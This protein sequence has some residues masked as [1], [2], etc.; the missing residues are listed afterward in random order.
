MRTIKIIVVTLFVVFCM[1]FFTSCSSDEIDI[2]YNLDEQILYITLPET[3]VE[4]DYL[5]INEQN[6]LVQTAK[7]KSNV[8]IEVRICDFN[9]ENSED[10][11]KQ[12]KN[13]LKSL[14]PLASAY[15]DAID[16]NISRDFFGSSLAGTFYVHFDVNN[17]SEED[18][19]IRY[20]RTKPF[21]INSEVSELKD[22]VYVIEK[23]LT[24]KTDNI[25]Y[26]MEYSFLE[27]SNMNITLNIENP[28]PMI[29]YTMTHRVSNTQSLKA[30]MEMLGLTVEFIDAGNIVLYERYDTMDDFNAMF[31][32]RLYAIFGIVATTKYEHKS[33][34]TSDASIEVQFYHIPENLSLSLEI[35]SQ[36]NTLFTCSFGNKEQ[37]TTGTKFKIDAKND[38]IVKA[39][40]SNVRW[41]ENITSVLAILSVAMV[42]FGMIYLGKRKI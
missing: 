27:T 1:L 35:E 28:S 18:I 42:I 40:Y 16:V 11:I 4:P 13:T 21:M 26:E 9:P 12:V 5:K 36:D 41:F 20:I 17:K 19:K 7:K 15:I 23:T 25:K 24:A 2:V 34:F 6:L 32:A 22:D 38:L 37:S 3:Y 31:S 30:E 10:N 8:E 29:T 33:F 14:I 39:T